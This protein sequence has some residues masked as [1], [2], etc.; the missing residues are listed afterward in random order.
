[1][2]KRWTTTRVN[3]PLCWECWA[4]HLHL[5]T[6]F[7]TQ[8]SEFGSEW[9]VLNISILN[10]F[11]MQYMGTLHALQF[12]SAEHSLSATLIIKS[13]F[14]CS[15]QIFANGVCIQC[16]NVQLVEQYNKW[17]PS[18]CCQSRACMEHF[19]IC[20]HTTLISVEVLSCLERQVVLISPTNFL[21]V[22]PLFLKLHTENVGQ[23]TLPTLLFSK[24]TRY[25]NVDELQ[26]WW[27]KK[28]GHRSMVPHLL[29]HL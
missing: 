11:Q 5:K 19:I 1:M 15:L 24:R 26:W 29:K 25:S 10:A 6:T 9:H 20:I 17:P 7:Y 21:E 28:D 12:H 4:I 8:N 27:I 3:W 14:S 2:E 16:H 18:G 13:L 22:H 23:R